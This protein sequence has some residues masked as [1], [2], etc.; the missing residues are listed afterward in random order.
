MGCK[1]K[2]AVTGDGLFG[3]IGAGVDGSPLG[4]MRR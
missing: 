2:G 4:G 1:Y 3:D